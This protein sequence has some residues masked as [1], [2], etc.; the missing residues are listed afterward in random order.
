MFTGWRARWTCCASSDGQAKSH[1]SHLEVNYKPLRWLF[2]KAKSHLSVSNPAFNGSPMAPGSSQVFRANLA[3]EV[4]SSRLQV[5]LPAH[6][7]MSLRLVARDGSARAPMSEPLAVLFSDEGEPLQVRWELWA[8][9]SPDGQPACWSGLPQELQPCIEA[10][11][12]E[13]HPKVA[14]QLP[15]EGPGGRIAAPKRDK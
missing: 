14:L 15:S 13:G 4:S 11:W 9:R 3:T 1:L 6:V 10:A 12:L 2:F 7:P 5:A 8:R